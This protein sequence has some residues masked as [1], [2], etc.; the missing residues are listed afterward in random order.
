MLKIAITG[1]IASGKSVV[2]SILNEKG[3][4]VFDSDK[5][6]H[7]IMSFDASAISEIKDL[8]SKYDVLDSNG[9]LSREKIGKIVFA[10]KGLLKGLESIIHPRIFKLLKDYFE[11]KKDD[12]YLF[13]S[14]PVLYEAN[15][16]H[17]FDKVLLIAADDDIRL[18]RLIKRNNFSVEYAKTRIESQIPQEEKI[19]LADYVIYNNGSLDQL[20]SDVESFLTDLY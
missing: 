14:V 8:L 1:N 3:I 20:K 18:D 6:S 9:D 7:D 17:Y 19:K 11:S 13:A 2:E 5:A 12:K 16:S 4:D 15:M 10:N